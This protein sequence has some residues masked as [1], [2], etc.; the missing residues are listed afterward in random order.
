MR[1]L[2]AALV[3][4]LGGLI[5]VATAQ[6][7]TPTPTAVDDWTHAWEVVQLV[8]AQ[9]A[10]SVTVYLLGDSVARES[11]VDDAAWTAQLQERAAAAGRASPTA[12]TIAGHNQTFGMDRQLIRALPGTPEGVPRGIVIISVGLSRFIGPPLTQPPAVVE[13]PPAGGLPV[14]SVWE[15]HRYSDREP[16]SRARK[17]ALVRRWMERRWD[18]FVG[19]RFANLVAILRLVDTCRKRGLRPVLLD[20]PLDL[21]VVRGGLDAPRDSYRSA[22]R[23]IAR[24]HHFTY[25]AYADPPRLP[26]ACFWDLMH[27]LPPGSERWQSR[28]SDQLVELLPEAPPAP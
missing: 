11:V 18:G 27:L 20:Q 1:V 21:V 10:T 25:L 17:R 28:L 3:C 6:A 13:P 4:A 26:T 9:P 14:L 7:D 8:Q 22:C 16:L 23:R 24:R 15:R 19:N 5:L 2:A 12:F